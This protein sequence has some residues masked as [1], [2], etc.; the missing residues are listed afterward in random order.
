MNPE[1]KVLLERTLKLSEENNELLKKIE[2][3]AR[4]AML[5]G[6]LK[7]A[8]IVTPFVAGYILLQPFFGQFGDA[9]RKVLEL[10]NT[11]TL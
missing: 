9:A 8:I 5:W 10:L 1:D 6:F 3:K 2:T 11:P 4:W 7:V